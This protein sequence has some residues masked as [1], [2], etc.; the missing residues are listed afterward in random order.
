MPLPAS[1]VAAVGLTSMSKNQRPRMVPIRGKLG[2]NSV[3]SGEPVDLVI[4]AHE[5]LFRRT[6][7]S[8]WRRHLVVMQFVKRPT[9]SSEH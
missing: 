6:E 5:V 4:Q 9:A 7:E 1:G 8:S 2:G 3:D